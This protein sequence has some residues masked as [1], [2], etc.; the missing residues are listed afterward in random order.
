MLEHR[1]EVVR[2]PLDGELARLGVGEYLEE[3]HLSTREPEHEPAVG[4]RRGAQERAD[5]ESIA[6]GDVLTE[7][8]GEAEGAEAVGRGEDDERAG[9]RPPELGIGFELLG[10]IEDLRDLRLVETELLEFL[11]GLAHCRAQ[12]QSQGLRLVRCAR[13]R[14]GDA[15]AALAPVLGEFKQIFMGR[16]ITWQHLC[17]LLIRPESSVI[18]VRLD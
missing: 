14:D 8:I 2:E 3:R 5:I 12:L 9:L 10:R 18:V 15:D 4:E 6:H 13:G 1:G 17:T 11:R 7:T 16:N